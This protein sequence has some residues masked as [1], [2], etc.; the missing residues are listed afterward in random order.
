M[1]GGGSATLRS[2]GNSPSTAG[3]APAEAA[4]GAATGAK[5]FPSRA[6]SAVSATRFMA[7]DRL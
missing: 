6:V 4:A 1:A 7:F 2:A 5:S 3:G